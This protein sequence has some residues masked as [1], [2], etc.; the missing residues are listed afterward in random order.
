MRFYFCHNKNGT[1]TIEVSERDMVML[2]NASHTCM[3][4]L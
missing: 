3:P 1:L 2:K 4:W